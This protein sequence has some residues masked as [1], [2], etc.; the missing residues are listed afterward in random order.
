M[1]DHVTTSWV[2]DIMFQHS[3]NASQSPSQLDTSHL[4]SD[5]FDFT[6]IQVRHRNPRDGRTLPQQTRVKRGYSDPHFDF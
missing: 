6:D 2:S 5:C 3:S 4:V 1:A